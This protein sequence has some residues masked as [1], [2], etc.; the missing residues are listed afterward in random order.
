M[1]WDFTIGFIIGTILYFMCKLIFKMF[2]RAYK[3]RRE[4]TQHEEARR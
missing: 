2:K 1:L 3:I 4:V